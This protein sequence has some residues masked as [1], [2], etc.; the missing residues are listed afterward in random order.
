M[1]H[2]IVLEDVLDLINLS[3]S[4]PGVI[5]QRTVA[6]LRE[7]AGRMLHWARAMIHPDGGIAF[8]NDAAFGVAADFVALSR[9]AERLGLPAV[10]K[11][12]VPFNFLPPADTLSF[13]LSW[14]QQRVICNSGTS[15][16]GHG[17]MRQWERSTAAH[18]TITVDGQDSSEVWGGFRVARRARPFGLRAERA[19]D[20]LQLCCGHDGY[21]RLVGKPMHYRTVEISDQEVVWRDEVSGRGHH[22]LTGYIPIHPEVAVEQMEECHWRLKLPSGQSLILSRDS[23]LEFS[24]QEGWYSPEFGKSLRRPV[25]TWRL[26]GKLPL[27]AA[28][29]L[30]EI[31]I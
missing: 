6:V 15:R 14:G 27:A 1:Y 16:Y 21:G 7:A 11:G 18:N 4:H 2:A 19:G 3:R 8:F 12:R 22:R 13:E 24:I 20:T 23:G 10:A 25:L 29:R 28:F 9:Y 17:A 31:G 30:R 26:E 5:P